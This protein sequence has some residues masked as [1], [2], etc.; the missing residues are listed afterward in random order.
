MPNTYNFFQS[1]ELLAKSG[2][3]AIKIFSINL[4]L[5]YFINLFD[6]S[7]IFNIESKSLKIA[8]CKIYAKN[9]YRIRPLVTLLPCLRDHIPRKDKMEKEIIQDKI[10]APLEKKITRMR[11][12]PSLSII[13][14][15]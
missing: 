2:P 4:M 15:N 9:L 8:E 11:L 10:E 14:N 3:D 7:K 5:R 1:G 13:Q 12:I 6:R